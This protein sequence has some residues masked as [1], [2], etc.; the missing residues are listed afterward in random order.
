MA[1]KSAQAEIARTETA[2]AEA[3][4]RTA[5]AE[6]APA[7]TGTPVS[8]AARSKPSAALPK[9]ELVSRA[10]PAPRSAPAPLRSESAASTSSPLSG[11]AVVG[12]Y[13]LQENAYALRDYYR[14][15]NVRAGVERVMANGRP[16]YQVRVW[17]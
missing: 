3:A 12:S 14:S 2:R 5:Q 13:A 1:Q 11:G 17:R 8:E 10:E 9:I 15:Q 16:M 7:R 4:R 6:T